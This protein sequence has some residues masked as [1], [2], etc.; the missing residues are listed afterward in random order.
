MFLESVVVDAADPTGV[1]RFWDGLLDIGQR[2]VAWVVLTDPAG[3]SFC[4]LPVRRG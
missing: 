1:G 4:L 2:D 3:H